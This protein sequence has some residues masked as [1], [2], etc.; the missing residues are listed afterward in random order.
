MK[1]TILTIGWDPNLI[2]SILERIEERSELSFQFK[3]L[4]EV[5]TKNKALTDTLPENLIPAFISKS[6]LLHRKTGSFWK[7]LK[8]MGFLQSEQ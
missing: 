1:H 2:N 7:V 3:H 5:A 6:I 4:V 8:E